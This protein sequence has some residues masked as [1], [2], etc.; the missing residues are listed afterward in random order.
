MN[1]PTKN[2]AYNNESNG[3]TQM[4]TL[5][6]CKQLADSGRRQDTIDC[7]T[8]VI[9]SMAHTTTAAKVTGVH[10][11]SIAGATTELDNR[12]A[13]DLYCLRGLQHYQL[14]NF[15]EA[16]SDYTSALGL[17]P[18]HIDSLIHRA[19]VHYRLLRFDAAL[20]DLQSALDVCSTDERV[21]AALRF[22]LE[23]MASRGMELPPQ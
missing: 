4:D 3:R 7:I 11:D 5:S 20:R 2:E 9:T 16:V 13:A 6:K 10:C 19:E 14:V 21:I 22:V 15:D 1:C 18:H 17:C 23:D 8:A 12:T